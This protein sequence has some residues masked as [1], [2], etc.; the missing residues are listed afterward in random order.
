MLMITMMLGNDNILWV[1]KKFVKPEFPTIW[2]LTPFLVSE[3]LH[4][5][6]WKVENHWQIIEIVAI[7]QYKLNILMKFFF[8]S[9]IGFDDRDP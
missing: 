9:I 8:N 4:D 5:S 2:I 7:I 6:L 3:Y 1:E